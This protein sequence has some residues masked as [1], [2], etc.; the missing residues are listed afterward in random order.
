MVIYADGCFL[1]S[2]TRRYRGIVPA[3]PY[4]LNHRQLAGALLL[5]GLLFFIGA[6]LRA[7]PT[8]NLP[9]AGGRIGFGLIAAMM[10]GFAIYCWTFE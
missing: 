3:Q 1:I 4:W 9:T 10:G 8:L 5:V 6:A 7:A 2:L